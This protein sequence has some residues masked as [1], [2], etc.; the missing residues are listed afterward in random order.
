MVSTITCSGEQAETGSSFARG[1]PS[2]EQLVPT[3]RLAVVRRGLFGGGVQ[4]GEQVAGCD[5]VDDVVLQDVAEPDVENS[6]CPGIR[7]LSPGCGS[8]AWN[9]ELDRHRGLDV[10]IVRKTNQA[11]IPIRIPAEL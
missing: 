10:T 8:L 1:D 4:I 7:P 9:H 6:F 3:L 2:F 5:D 11:A